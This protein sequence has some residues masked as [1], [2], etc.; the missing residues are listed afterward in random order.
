MHAQL[1]H[2]APRTP[3]LARSGLTATAV[4]LALAGL[5][6]PAHAQ[7]ETEAAAAGAERY[8]VVSGDT[9]S[10][11]AE[12]HGLD[13]TVGWRLLFDANPDVADPDVILP[14]QQLRIPAPDEVL[15]RRAL[16]AAPAPSAPS[17]AT[18]APQQT[19]PAPDPAPAPAPAATT[20]TPAGVWD[21]L[22]QCESGGNWQA[23]TGNG[24][25]GGLQFLPATWRAVGG[26]GLPHEASREEQIQ[27]AQALQASAGW[28]QWPA[29]SRELGL[30]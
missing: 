27:R 14:G 19:T 2:R 11:I 3:A 15:E 29:C 4:A 9:L 16:P 8:E 12:E 24:Y 20:S 18:P 6:T 23:N 26:T 22:A 5:A 13:A 21:R 7:G 1:A 30:R 25:Y 17:A 10:A 28:G